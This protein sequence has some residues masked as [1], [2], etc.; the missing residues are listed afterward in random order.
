MAPEVLCAQNH[1]YPVD[2]FAI[3]VMGY[4]F[5]F[6]QRP[7]LGRS[8][9]EIKQVV[10]RKQ[11]QI[12]ENE[13]PD[14][15][16]LESVD[17]I[18]RLLQRKE[19]KRLG[20]REGVKEL[21]AHPWFKG[22]DWDRL[23]NKTL[24]SP[25]TPKPEGNYDKKYC[26]SIEKL[27]AETIERYQSY[28]KRDNFSYLFLNYT[29]EGIIDF[30]ESQEMLTIKLNITRGTKTLLTKASTNTTSTAN[31]NINEIK[32]SNVNAVDS[33][34]ETAR[35][36]VSKIKINKIGSF[37]RLRD[38]IAASKNILLSKKESL[39]SLPET[40]IIPS[41]SRNKNLF[42]NNN[43]DDN[44]IKKQITT[45]KHNFH[46]KKLENSQSC[47]LLQFP[48]ISNNK[49]REMK[50]FLP[51]INVD[52]AYRD[53]KV[54]LYKVNNI[55]SLHKS[56]LPIQYNPM[57]NNSTKNICLKRSDSA[58]MLYGSFFQQNPE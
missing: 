1:S 25:F 33:G 16:S 46:I 47:K 57:L 37:Q 52:S 51:L 10:M 27:S 30:N 55:R 49:T 22:F 56:K 36:Q 18:N 17:F 58:G 14:D 7:Y 4:E 11:V 15:W 38:K 24:V 26:E 21:R 53:E 31:N 42:I 3:G 39:G 35:R 40:K 23:Y 6:G 12:E 45:L 9:K 2:Y 43:E 28:M 48:P 41:N 13:I 50:S 19:T 32:T 34:N 8:R 5:M 54:S 20:Y 44:G 29:Y